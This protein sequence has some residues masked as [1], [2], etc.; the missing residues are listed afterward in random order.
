MNHILTV[1]VCCVLLILTRAVALAGSPTAENSAGLLDLLSSGMRLM[2]VG[3]HPDDEVV[4]GPLLARAA[5]LTEVLVV[6]LTDGGGG[7]NRGG[8]TLAGSLGEARALELAAACKVLGVEHR[9]LGFE[10]EPPDDVRKRMIREGRDETAGQAI[11]RWRG[12]GRDPSAEIVRVIRQWKPDILLSFDAEQ[13]FTLHREHQAV[14]LLARAAIPDAADPARY[15]EQLD[16]GLQPW[17]VTRWYTAVNRFPLARNARIPRVD[18]SRIAEL[19]DG[20]VRSSR[21]GRTYLDVAE[22]AAARHVTQFGGGFFTP[23]RSAMFAQ[24][25]REQALILEYADDGKP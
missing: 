7:E 18:E 8:V 20:Q 3:A 1:P 17:Q 24:E 14:A 16:D 12:S 23:A 9:L 5:E 22:E 21:R 11:E 6:C 19:I 15:P 4:V 2:Y 10:N 13:G 25:M